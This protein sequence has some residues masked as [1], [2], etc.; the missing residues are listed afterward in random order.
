MNFD[1]VQNIETPRDKFYDQNVILNK[2]ENL[3]WT[4]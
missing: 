3:G 4:N 2:L 1:V